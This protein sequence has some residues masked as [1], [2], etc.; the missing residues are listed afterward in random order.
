MDSRNYNVGDWVVYRRTKH[1]E[2]P[3]PRAKNVTS[4]A[5]GD[6]YSYTVDKYWI[7]D[8]IREDGCLLLKTRLGKEHVVDVDDPQL[9]RASW[10]ERLLYRQRFSQVA[11]GQ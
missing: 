10:W 3:G 4:A 2:S 6:G 8:A 11:A 1:S 5:K 7:V 9:H